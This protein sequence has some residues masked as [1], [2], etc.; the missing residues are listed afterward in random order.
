[1][2]VA[3]IWNEKGRR[4]TW[5]DV[6]PTLVS[7]ISRLEARAGVHSE[8][9][10]EER[11]SALVTICWR[12]DTQATSSTNSDRSVDFEHGVRLEGSRVGSGLETTRCADVLRTPLS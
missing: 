9:W 3:D 8:T 11:G 10:R 5:N 7:G 6:G 4:G 12:Q 1:M 2:P